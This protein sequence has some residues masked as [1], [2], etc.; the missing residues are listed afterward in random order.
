MHVGGALSAPLAKEKKG[1]INMIGAVYF[2]Y[3]GVFSGSYGLKI[4]DFDS[5]NIGENQAFS[6]SLSLLKTPSKIRFYHG[7]L[8]YNEP[9]SFEFSVI[10]ENVI[11]HELR[12][13]ILSWLVGRGSFLP[14]RFHDDSLES[15]TYYC[16]FTE[17]STIYVNGACHGFKLTATFDS[18]FARGESTSVTTTSGANHVSIL[19]RSDLFYRYTYPVVEFTGGSIDIVNLTDDISRH[20]TMSGFNQS[21]VVTVDNEV[22]TITCS[23][24]GDNLSKFTSKHWLRLRPGSNTLLVVSNGDVTITCPRYAMIGI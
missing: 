4:A 1:E 3:A 16:V 13:S 2:T 12:T 22:K 17:S 19:N 7:G 14:L 5:S 8:E 21:D 10:S 15:F 6:P 24:P 20:F 9:V 23:T 18:P 11:P